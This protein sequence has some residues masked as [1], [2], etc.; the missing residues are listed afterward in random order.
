MR[1]DLDIFW[2]TEKDQQLGRRWL[3]PIEAKSLE[4]RRA[5]LSYAPNAGP[6]RHAR[7]LAALTLDDLAN[8]KQAAESVLAPLQAFLHDLERRVRVKREEEGEL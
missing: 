1:D 5:L 7:A 2:G 8:A 6:N 3:H 4:L